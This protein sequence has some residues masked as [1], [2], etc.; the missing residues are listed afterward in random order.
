MLLSKERVHL[1]Y[2]EDITVREK[3][4]I[5]NEVN[6]RFEEIIKRITTKLSWFD[7]D[8]G[9]DETDGYFDIH[10]DD[11]TF[12]GDF[13]LIPW[14]GDDWSFPTRWLYIDY[15]DELMQRV[16]ENK[17]IKEEL[18]AKADVLE[19]REIINIIKSKLSKKELSSITFK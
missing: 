5:L 19:K 8:N 14:F 3:K 13:I 16:K 15:E 11:I 17:S 2:S 10:S 7:F 12:T 4:E 6:E 18:I 1:L 9:F